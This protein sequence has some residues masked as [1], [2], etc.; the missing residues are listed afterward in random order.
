MDKILKLAKIIKN[1]KVYVKRMPSQ[2]MPPPEFLPSHFSHMAKCLKWIT[3]ENRLFFVLGNTINSELTKRIHFLT[4][5]STVRKISYRQWIKCIRLFT[6][7][8]Y[9]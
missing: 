7:I 4:L 1:R 5:N 9:F 3:A 2:W 6:I 8:L